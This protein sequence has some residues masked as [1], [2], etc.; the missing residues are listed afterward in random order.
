M[1]LRLSAAPP[2][3]LILSASAGQS[4]PTPHRGRSHY[5]APPAATGKA[6]LHGPGTAGAQ[7]Q[8][9]LLP[10]GTMHGG[11]WPAELVV[12]AEAAARAS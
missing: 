1:K 5:P 8:P 10:H 6:G 7:M 12:A 2:C 11:P 3:L 4:A 9:L